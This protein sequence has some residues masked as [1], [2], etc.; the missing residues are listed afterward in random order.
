MFEGV[1]SQVALY[2]R[3]IGT[4]AAKEAG[5]LSAFDPYVVVEGRLPYIVQATI[6]APEAVV[7][8]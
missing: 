2:F 4:V 8:F 6:R 7:Q 5:L 3:F 1:P